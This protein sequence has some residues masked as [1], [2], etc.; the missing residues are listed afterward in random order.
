M[1]CKYQITNHHELRFHAVLCDGG[2]F[3]PEGD[4]LACRARIEG[5][6]QPRDAPYAPRTAN[7]DEE[8]Y[9]DPFRFSAILWPSPPRAYGKC[10]FHPESQQTPYGPDYAGW[11]PP[12]PLFLCQ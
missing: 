1:Q 8:K 10:T 12:R 4:D 7:G 5:A 6:E 9:D 3:V 11:V 2:V